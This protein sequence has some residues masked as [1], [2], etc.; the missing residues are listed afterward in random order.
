MKPNRQDAPAAPRPSST[1]FD[2]ISLEFFDEQSKVTQRTS[3]T[4]NLVA[5]DHIMT[6][7]ANCLHEVIKTFSG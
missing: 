7:L 4:I 6:M 1:R 3:Q 2:S 5:R